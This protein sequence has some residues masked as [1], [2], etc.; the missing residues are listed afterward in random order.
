MVES[1]TGRWWSQRLVPEA[2]RER[3]AVSAIAA[4]L[5]SLGVI[6]GMLALVVDVGGIMWER[7]QLQNGADAAA[8]ALAADCATQSARCVVGN[9][10]LQGLANANA[11]DKFSKVDTVC[12]VGTFPGS[13][14]FPACA[15]GS[16]GLA[17]CLPTPAG[18]TD[19]VEVRTQTSTNATNT[20]TLLKPFFAQFFGNQGTSV[21]ACARASWSA[22]YPSVVFPVTQAQCAWDSA[23]NVGTDFPAA[24]PYALTGSGTP[25]LT[26][27]PRVPVAAKYVTKIV[28][29]TGNG[30]FDGTSKCGSTGPGLYTPGNFGWLDTDAS[31]CQATLGSDVG[32]FSAG[33][34][35]ASAPKVCKD[36][37][38]SLIGSIIYIPI[39]TSV[40][41]QG[42]NTT[43]TFDGVSAFYFAGYKVPGAGDDGFTPTDPSGA[44][45]VSC[46]GEK[47]CM[48]GWF[49]T[50]IIPA[51]QVPHGTSRGPRTTKVVG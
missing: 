38:T 37:M 33:K 18:V 9:P 13:A 4:M 6:I 5:L 48:W 50:P 47:D 46:S 12:A 43:Y 27:L 21:R 17:D 3:G 36:V 10:D 28:L 31:G 44:S 2:D 34:P 26:P 32:A 30:T 23:T 15:A 40:T 19:F 20:G 45:T 49:V 22:G 29:H 42:N 1:R 25:G 39:F 14:A 24:P 35:G 11:A 7:R 51:A 8:L 16:A 41:G